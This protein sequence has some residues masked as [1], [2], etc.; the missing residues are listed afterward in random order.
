V[1]VTF[2]LRNFVALDSAPTM[3]E[4]GVQC[5]VERAVVYRRLVERSQTVSQRCNGLFGMGDVLRSGGIAS[6]K[7][8]QYQPL[9]TVRRPMIENAGD[10]KSFPSPGQPLMLV[11]EVRIH[12]RSENLHVKGGTSVLSKPPDM[13]LRMADPGRL[14]RR[15]W[16]RCGNLRRQG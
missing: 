5:E 3:L 8:A 14:G 9:D 6:R 11:G 4:R 1:E 15:V 10:R 13:P 12:A 2:R 16:K 7:L